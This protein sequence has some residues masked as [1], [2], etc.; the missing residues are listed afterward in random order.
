MKLWAVDGSCP[1]VSQKALKVDEKSLHDLLTE[2]D[3]VGNFVLLFPL[4]CTDISFQNL[5]EAVEDCHSSMKHNVEKH[6][7]K[8]FDTLIPK[9]SGSAIDVA[10]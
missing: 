1:T 8:T 2:L 9:A 7:Y 10:M 6:V 5:R 3:S 4:R